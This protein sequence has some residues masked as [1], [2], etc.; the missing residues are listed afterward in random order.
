MLLLKTNDNA[1]LVYDITQDSFIFSRVTQEVYKESRESFLA[2]CNREDGDERVYGID[3]IGQAF[4]NSIPK[5]F[6]LI[7]SVVKTNPDTDTRF[8]FDL[9]ANP[10]AK[11]CAICGESH[12]Y[13]FSI[14]GEWVCQD[15]IT[16]IELCSDCGKVLKIGSCSTI[17]HEGKRYCKECRDTKFQRCEYCGDWELIQNLVSVHM[18]NGDSKKVCNRCINTQFYLCADCGEYYYRS[19]AQEVVGHGDVCPSCLSS[20]RYKECNACGHWHEVGSL[21]RDQDDDELYCLSCYASRHQCIHSHWSKLKPIFHGVGPL[22]FGIEQEM[23]D[24]DDPQDTAEQIMEALGK[25]ELYIETDGSLNETGLELVYH[26]RDWNEWNSFVPKLEEVRQIASNSGYKAHDTSTCGLHI[27]ASRCA[28]RSDTFPDIEENIGK[29]IALYEN[30]YGEFVKFSRRRQDDLDQWAKR[31]SYKPQKGEPKKGYVLRSPR[32]R[33]RAVNTVPDS[34]L[35]FRFFRGTLVP[36]T[37]LAAI[38]LVK[39]MIELAVSTDSDDIDTISFDQIMNTEKNPIIASYW[40]NLRK[41]R[42]GN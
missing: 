9:R 10:P 12:E 11:K 35:E 34:T 42:R 17:K 22:Y 2:S 31:N 18:P 39:N 29:I 5:Q 30:N 15:C 41:P 25:K 37:V 13:L 4:I 33:Y 24:G 1:S 40:D 16:K 28:I 23:D 21:R 3:Y 20:G 32:D 7:Q 8:L 27:H 6:A 38:N 14:N 36:D 19:T 26:P